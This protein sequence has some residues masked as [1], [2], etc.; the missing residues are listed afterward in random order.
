MTDFEGMHS[1]FWLVTP[2]MKT[3]AR[4]DIPYTDQALRQ[5]LLRVQ[6]A[7]DESQARRERDAIYIYLTAVFE[8]VAWWMAENRAL[9]RA[10]RAL[11]L[12]HITPFDQEEPFAA[13]IRCTANP[14]KVDKRTRSK[15]SRALRNALAYKLTSEPLDQFMKRKGGINE[16]AAKFARHIGRGCLFAR[17]IGLHARPAQVLEMNL[18]KRVAFGSRS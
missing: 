16:C 15:W 14:D 3:S 11:R 10:Q 18:V 1:Y 8:L 6:N 2:R 12:R 9:E 4:S 13:I 5:D 7:W 17:R